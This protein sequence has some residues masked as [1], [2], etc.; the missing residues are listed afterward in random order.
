MGRIKVKRREVRYGIPA[1][2]VREGGWGMLGIQEEQ[3][4]E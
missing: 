3:G 4:E 2:E 1:A